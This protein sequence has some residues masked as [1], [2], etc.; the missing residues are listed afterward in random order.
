MGEEILVWDIQSW[1]LH[2][3]SPENILQSQGSTGMRKSSRT[4]GAEED[5]DIANAPLSHLP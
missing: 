5:S 2:S 4:T 1:R 3:R